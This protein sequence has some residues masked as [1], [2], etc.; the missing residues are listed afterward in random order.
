MDIRDLACL[1]RAEV[2]LAELMETCKPAN[3]LAV[4]HAQP[5]AA[6]RTKAQALIEALAKLKQHL[7]P[8]GPPP[9]VRAKEPLYLRISRP[10]MLAIARLV[11]YHGVPEDELYALVRDLAAEH[12]KQAVGLAMLELTWVDPDTR[13]T[14]LRPEVIRTCRVAIG[15]PPGDPAYELYWSTRGGVPEVRTPETERQKRE[16]ARKP[17]EETQPKRRGG[18][19]KTAAKE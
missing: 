14:R 10:E 11:G 15:P 17:V 4:K 1:E 6:V 8:A 19:Q 2:L 3:S 16:A 7:D 12:D 18:K 9:T 5:T 13:W